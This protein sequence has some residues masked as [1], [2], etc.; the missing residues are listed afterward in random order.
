[1]LDV[2]HNEADDENQQQQR[3]GDGKRYSCCSSV[4]VRRVKE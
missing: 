3:H 4:G 2:Q 1:M